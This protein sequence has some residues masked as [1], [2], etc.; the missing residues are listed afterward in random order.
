[1]L[2]NDA[3]FSPFMGDNKLISVGLNPL[4]IRTASEQLFT[5]LLPGL[6][7]VTLRI[8][9]YSFYCWLIREFYKDR[10][11]ASSSDFKRH[12]RMS[13]LLIALIHAQSTNNQGLP[14]IDRALAIIARGEKSINFNEDAMPNGEPKNGYWKA[15]SYGAFGSYYAASL[16]EM[17]IIA[18]L[19]DNNKL[20]NITPHNE[21]YISGEDL[22]EAFEQS[23][24][25]DMSKLFIE[26]S[27]KGVVS[28][29]Q[30]AQMETVFQ[31]HNL[32]DNKER[33]LLLEMLLQ[34]DKPSTSEE[35]NFRKESLRLL[36][37]YL[38]DYNEDGFSELA[39]AKHVYECYNNGTENSTAAV[40]WYAYYLNDSRQFEALKIFVEL[41]RRLESSN[42]PGQ[43]EYIEDFTS[44][45]AEEICNMLKVP[46]SITVGEIL[47]NWEKIEKPNDKI[48]VSFYT[49]LDNYYNNQ[50]YKESK[51]IIRSYY[52]KV[53][54]DA[55]DAF[56]EIERNLNDSLFFFVKKYLTENIIYNHYSESMRK[57]TQNGI[58]TQK[59]TIENGYVRGIATF[60]I[61]HSSPRI[62]TLK[63]FATDLGLI[64]ANRTNEEGQKLLKRLQND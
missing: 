10:K 43:W 60:K 39:F 34:S 50:S 19:E 20:Y 16:R 22:A 47:S 31:C 40:G 32:C 62:Q 63:E 24:G 3:H 18:P 59:L 27:R 14:G 36:L 64:S 13:E 35:S 58:P 30:L 2:N 17:G 48:A 21:I 53:N 33:S 42:K 12:I 7:V 61:S 8:R 41:L 38:K 28:R 51:S 44:T 54:N 26:C 15:S 37:S 45:L 55:M 46:K 1:M 6:N 9:Y 4:G 23:I 25:V 52:C 56:D 57:F 5:T 11:E 29:K 49:I